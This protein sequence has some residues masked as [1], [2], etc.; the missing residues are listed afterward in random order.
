MQVLCSYCVYTR[1][2]FFFENPSQRT[3]IQLVI[4]KMSMHRKKVR[5]RCYY[6][7]ILWCSL[8]CFSLTIILMI[9]PWDP[10]IMYGAF[11]KEEGESSE[12]QV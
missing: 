7:H 5:L 9:T 8:P 1:G 10:G 2:N 3:C 12:V 4:Y 6:F 11:Y